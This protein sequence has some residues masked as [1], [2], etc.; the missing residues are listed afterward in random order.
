MEVTGKRAMIVGGASGMARATAELLAQRGATI[1]IL[2]LPS[3]AGAEVA[4]AI[5]AVF[6]PCDVTDD[7]G[8]ERALASA[9][10]ALGGLHIA[11]NTVGGEQVASARSRAPSR[12]RS[13]SSDASSS[14]TWSRRST[15]TACRRGTCA[16]TSPKTASAA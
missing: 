8:A 6:V 7:E 13:T 12:T 10:E 5:D 14:S 3:S 9:V 16:R 15:S 4:A 2:D 1:A 11:V